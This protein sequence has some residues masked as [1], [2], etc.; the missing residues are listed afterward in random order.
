MYSWVPQYLELDL[1]GCFILKQT[2]VMEG[3]LRNALLQTF[4]ER[5][6]TCAV[7]KVLRRTFK[8]LEVEKP[9]ATSWSCY[10]LYLSTCHKNL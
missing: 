4:L 7:F 1:R 6:M 2:L 9:W 10:I 8:N 3:F 5:H